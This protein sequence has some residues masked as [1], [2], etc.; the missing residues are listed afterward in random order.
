[1][2]QLYVREDGPMVG[3]V[4]ARDSRLQAPVHP[5]ASK[6]VVDLKVWYEA[7]PSHILPNTRVTTLT[8]RG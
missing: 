2:L 8:W 3:I 6:A 1:M 5:G 4:D 7:K